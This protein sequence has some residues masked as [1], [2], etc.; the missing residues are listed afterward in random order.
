MDTNQVFSNPQS[1]KQILLY[2]YGQQTTDERLSESTVENNGRGFNGIDAAFCSSVAKWV[3]E[4]RHLSDKQLM[5]LQLRLPKYR[6][7]LENGE[8]HNVAVPEEVSSAPAREKSPYAGR[9]ELDPRTQGLVFIPHTY[10]S[11]QIK[12]LGAWY[13][14]NSAW[15]QQ[16][17]AVSKQ[18]VNDLVKMFKTVDVDPSV[19]EFISPKP[20]E[21]PQSISEHEILF[22]FQKETIAFALTYKKAMIALAPGL[23]KTACAIFSAQAAK[24]EHVLIVAPLS[25]VYNW[26]N[27]IKKWTGE[28]SVIWYQKQLPIVGKWV[29]TNYDTLR[30]HPEQFNKKWD[31]VIVDESICIKNRHAKRTASVSKLLADTKPTF[32]WLLSGAPVSKLYDDMWSQLHAIA[33]S[34]FSSYWRF[35]QRYCYVEQDQWGWHIV[36]NRPEAAEGIKTELDDIYFARTQDQVLNLPDWIIEDVHVPMSAAQDKLYGQMEDSFMVSLQDGQTLSAPNVLSQLTRLIQL[37]S[38][39]VLVDATPGSAKWAACVEMLEYEKG[40]YI[41]WTTFIETANQLVKLLEGKYKVAI[42]N[43]SVP[44]SDRQRIVDEFQAGNI[45]IIVAHP[46]VGKFG[47]TL[48]AARTAIYLERSYN[49]DDYYQSLH[50]IRRIG[51]QYSPHVIHLI[52]DRAEGSGTVDHVINKILQSRRE[53][54]LALTTGELK[55]F[56]EEIRNG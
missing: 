37:A 48:T 12:E 7:Q 23:G 26:R 3:I 34:R 55:K 18:L 40:P 16:K 39:P 14:E 11:K 47:L 6:G 56:F 38:N 4:G 8:W 33:P 28:D 42:L 27:E 35:T 1:V 31:A 21:L 2:L 52:S 9:L 17:P 24:C 43:G 20:V 44:A 51:T 22:P 53:N 15:H 46:A 29:V 49:G 36:A 19:T 5:S 13:W 54:V 45:D 25:L 41:I 50:R 32:A 30:I 10:P